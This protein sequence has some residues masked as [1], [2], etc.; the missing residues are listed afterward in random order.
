MFLKYFL[1]KKK[2]GTHAFPSVKIENP[3]TRN[4]QF[5]QISDYSFPVSGSSNF[6]SALRNDEYFP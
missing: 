6:I 5:L 3:E 4:G 2:R 1:S